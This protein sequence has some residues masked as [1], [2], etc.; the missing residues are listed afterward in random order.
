MPEANTAKDLSNNGHLGRALDP[1]VA[2]G[3]LARVP[4]VLDAKRITAPDG[5]LP[6]F[7]LRTWRRMDASAQ[8]P[9]GHT[10]NG[11]KVW[12]LRDL[13]LWCAWGFPHRGEF[14][15]RLAAEENGR[16]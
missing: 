7:S 10:V 11:R 6:V 14:L 13:E 1:N 9:P 12:R 2:S 3:G 16:K 4:L 15:Q 5:P 8:M